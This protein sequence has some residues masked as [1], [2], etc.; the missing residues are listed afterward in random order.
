M[1]EPLYDEHAGRLHAYC[2][3]LIGEDAPGAVRDAFVSAARQGGPRGPIADRE[4]ELWLYGLARSACLRRETT[5][6]VRSADPL[7]RAAAALRPD[8]REVLTLSVGGR[9]ES[10]EIAAL[11]GVAADTLAQLRQ[12]GRTRL[13]RGVLDA[14]LHGP[15]STGQEQ[16]L[17]AFEKGTLDVLFAARMPAEPPA[18]LRD[19]VLISCA[20]ETAQPPAGPRVVITTPEQPAERS[21]RT[22]PVRTALAHEKTATPLRR[23][24]RAA[25]VTGTVGVAAGVAAAAGLFTTL[26]SS[27]ADT[28]FARNGSRH[29][30][31]A[32]SRDASPAA[33]GRT[34]T[35]PRRTGA[36]PA[37]SATGPLDRP[38]PNIA[39][40]VL[41]PSATS[42]RDPQGAVQPPDTPRPTTPSTDA[43]SPS[44][45]SASPSTPPS[46]TPPATPTPAPSDTKS[47]TTSPSSP[48]PT[49]STSP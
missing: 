38:S 9:L 39:P 34:A 1:Y 22:R 40:G 7:D 36:S 10:P 37:S 31:A 42:A 29:F 2:W 11:L 47:A 12:T 43:A 19:V 26:V 14:L 17:T 32:A 6:A 46:S 24:R 16:L 3:S 35:T 25:R 30:A 4:T 27:S 28:G 20:A 13:E 33:T 44:A 5:Y 18:D 15:V 23:A 48:A 41:P 21:G 45:P 8:Q 49:P